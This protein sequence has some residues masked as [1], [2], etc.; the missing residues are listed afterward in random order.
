[1]QNT[2][3]LI[4]DPQ[5]DFC[6]S[7]GALFVAGADKDMS[8]LA[9]MI[10]RVGAKLT[11]IHVTLDS[12]HLLDIAHPGFWKNSSGQ[13]P[14]PFTI[15]S[16]DD[17]ANGTW[18]PTIPS[19][20]K[21]ALSYTKA[22]KDN[23]RYLLCVWP[24]HCLIGSWG[25]QIVSDLYTSLLTWGDKYVANVDYVTKGSNF[26]TEHYSAVK[27]E[28]PDP[29]D[30]STQLNTTL[31]ESLEAVDNLVIAGEAGSHCLKF[32]LIDI[33]DALGGDK[34]V[35]KVTLLTDATSPVTGFEKDQDDFI[36]SM[37]ARG[38]K[39]STTNEF[40]K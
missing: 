3:L 2:Q 14:N 26:L 18:M 34:Y 12:H 38:M 28:V 29:A 36:N 40:L 7:K 15:I 35:S 33:V 8:R 39:L 13:K 6:D 11:D 32:T 31:T 19:F 20:S 10:D 22:L 23:G 25:T 5:N 17:V 24:A 9:K 1:M 37:V 16:Y 30:L 27:A 4:I 21:Y